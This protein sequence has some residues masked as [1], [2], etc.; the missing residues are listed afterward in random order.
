MLDS[1]LTE[2]NNGYKPESLS[3]GSSKEVYVKCD[4]CN[5]HTTKAYKAYLK[6]REVVQKDSCGNLKCKYA[7]REDISLAKHGVKN[8]A[9][10]QDVREK[11][12]DANIDRL[13]SDNFK[14]Q[15]KQTNL[16]KYGNENPMLVQSIAEK[17]KQTLIDKYGVDNI[18]KYS[19][20]AKQ[21][22]KK[23]KQ[24][25]INK[26]IIKVYD[27]KTRPEL[28][29]DIGFSRS[30]FGKLVV[31]YGIENALQMEPFK[32]KLEKTFELFLSEYHIGF[33]TQ[34]KIE[35]KIADFKINNLLIEVDGLYWHSDAAKMNADYHII[36]KTIYETNNYD[37]LFFREDE[38]RDKFHIVKSIVL[39]K[40]GRSQRIYAR[41]CT[42]DIIDDKEADSFFE[43]NHLMGKGRGTTYVLKNN[44][45]TVAAVRLK[46]MKNND[47]EISRFC[48]K[49][50]HNIIGGFSRLLK[51][52]LKD[53]KPEQLITFID[54]RYGKGDYLSRLG[55][56]YVHMYP[57][58][59]WTDG[60]ITFHRLKFPGNSGY[61]N[62]L[63]KI[64]DCGQAKWILTPQRCK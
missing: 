39:N 34:F 56:K 40:I 46:R 30:H 12:R 28:A 9:Q 62:G 15:A 1:D 58:F 23:M 44:D 8:S 37:S 10:R 51:Y 38:I 41:D 45:S 59:R 4:Y 53:K 31:K 5:E 21:A 17:Q 3:D 47:Y 32:T 63:F 25:K 61:D 54:K 64:W 16:E 20:M 7:K 11:I 49:V 2:K 6:Q 18:M 24:T 60:F 35:K 42:L 33:E 13:Q 55:F 36:K 48:T 29:Q 43:A 57:S 27:G 14:N 52:A 50:E 22:A 19:D 26:G